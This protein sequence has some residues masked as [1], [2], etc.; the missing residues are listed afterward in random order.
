[1]ELSEI[2]HRK[3]SVLLE[4]ATGI[5]KR[6]FDPDCCLNATRILVNILKN[7][8]HMKAT[9]LSVTATIF[10]PYMVEKGRPPE[11]PAE[12]RLWRDEG[13]WMVVVGSRGEAM[14]RRWP[15]H[16]VALVYG[17]WI[18]D[19]TVQQANRPEKNIEIKPLIFQGTEEFLRGERSQRITEPL[20]G[21][22]VFYDA[23]PE[24]KTWASKP[25]WC[26]PDQ[27]RRMEAEIWARVRPPSPDRS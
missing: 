11:S 15:G 1:M 21:C 22:A 26:V 18:V 5:F 27:S 19:A 9:A 17:S 8:M 3:L 20:N 23:F 12:G 10:N 6:R 25:G 7:R 2:Q 4:V 13:G 24:D 16:L 14:P